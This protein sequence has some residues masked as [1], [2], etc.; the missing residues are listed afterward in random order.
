MTLIAFIILFS[1][2]KDAPPINPQN[3]ENMLDESS[4]IYDSSGIVT[5]KIQA[6]QYRTVV[7]V[8]KVPENLLNAFIAIEDERFLLHNGVDFKRLVGVTLNGIKDREFTQGAS[9]ITMQLSK[10]LF[11]STDKTVKRKI[12]DMYYAVEIEKQLSKT[13]ILNAYVNTVFLGG[14]SNGVQAASKSYFNKDVSELNLAESAMIAGITKYPTMYIPFKTMDI[15]PTDD[16]NSIEI[17]LYPSPSP[18]EVTAEDMALYQK[19]RDNNVIDEYEF[20]LLKKGSIYPKKGV[21]NEKAVERM[22]TVLY[23]MLELNMITDNEYQDAIN[24]EIVIDFPPRT[25]AGIS[26]YFNDVVRNEAIDILIKIGN[27]EEKARDM[28]TSGGLRIYST[29]NTKI[30]KILEK[31]FSNS[32]NFPGNYHD[33]DGIVQPQGA[34][35]IIDQHTGHVVALIGG[36]EQA[37]K[38]IFNRA[39]SPRQPGSAIKPLAVYLPAIDRGLTKD[40]IV[41]DTKRPDKS[42]PTGYWP[43]NVDRVYRGDIT[44]ETALMFSSNVAAVR[45]MESLAPTR[46]ESVNI[47]LRYLE[48]MGISTIVRSTDNSRVNDENLSLAL[49]GMA[50]GVSPLEMTAAY[51]VVSNGG[52]MIAPT[53]ITKI[54]DARGNVIYEYEPLIKNIVDEYTSYELTKMLI[55]VVYRGWGGSSKLNNSITAGK[56]GTTSD[57][58]DFW[59]VG[60]TPY[61]TA[62]LWVGSD[63]PTELSG[64]SSVAGR[65]WKSVMDKVHQ[66]LPRIDFEAPKGEKPIKPNDLSVDNSENSSVD[67][68]E[69][70]ELDDLLFENIGGEEEPIQEPEKNENN[71][72]QPSSNEQK[73]NQG[74]ENTGENPNATNEEILEPDTTQMANPVIEEPHTNT[75]PPIFED[76]PPENQEG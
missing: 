26:S 31:E 69:S 33:E 54:E 35:V 19:L 67:P 34:M 65:F 36:R 47:S 71:P 50:K 38:M 30:Q 56:T 32:K 73:E 53:F 22:K 48:N 72:P 60:F 10:N 27:S 45:V 9:T 5:E 75:N 6:N 42:S 44:L 37:G 8:E 61:Y 16:V 25:N 7:P 18:K 46:L 3:I 29:M 39:L 2:V 68:N 55:S 1:I 13:Q 70:E 66:D 15:S 76:I 63:N 17:K 59:F 51:T 62:G 28:L 57:A 11:T 20:I 58:K 41:S 74:T 40:S 52:K 24:T 14:D 12:T 4:F 23:K 64:T 49:G 21:L 43:R